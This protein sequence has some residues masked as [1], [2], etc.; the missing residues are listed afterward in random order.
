[1]TKSYKKV[2]R[3]FTDKDYDGGY[4]T[5]GKL[6]IILM[7]KELIIK[8]AKKYNGDKF[9]MAKALGITVKCLYEKLTNHSLRDVI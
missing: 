8:S 3:V 6:S 2:I 9:L 5:E 4:D 1:M 7:E